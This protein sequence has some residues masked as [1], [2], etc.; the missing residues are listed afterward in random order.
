MSKRVRVVITTPAYHDHVLL[1]RGQVIWM[2]KKLLKD[3]RWAKLYQEP[4]H[5]PAMTP[6]DLGS[7]S[8]DE[9]KPQNENV[10]NSEGNV[11]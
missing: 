4:A 2:D 1:E 9:E 7:E 10:E 11:I 3:C 6:R 8:E 5:T